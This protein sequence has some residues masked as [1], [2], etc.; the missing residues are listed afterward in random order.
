V[1]HPR[2]RVILSAQRFGQE[3]LGRFRVLRGRQEK[4]RG[5]P[6]ES[7]ARYK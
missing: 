4:A 2:L 6:L 7:T 1:D 5:A 3:A